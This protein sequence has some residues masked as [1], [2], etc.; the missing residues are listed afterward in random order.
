MHPIPNPGE[1]RAEILADFQEALEDVDQIRAD[2]E[3]FLGPIISGIK[4]A[5]EQGHIS[6]EDLRE[7]LEWADAAFASAEEERVIQDS[8]GA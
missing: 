2:P 3:G 4:S 7:Q 5:A 8:E 1:L 6:A